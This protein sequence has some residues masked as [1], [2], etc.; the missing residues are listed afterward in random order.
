MRL[1][2][3]RI[4][5]NQT[6]RNFFHKNGLGQDSV[7]QALAAFGRRA[8]IFFFDE[9][10]ST[11]LRALEL[12]KNILNPFI[13]IAGKQ[14]AGRGRFDR[15]W[16][17]ESGKSICLSA[18][19]HL[20]ALNT[21]NLGLFNII[22]GICICK[23]LRLY[24]GADLL[25]KWPN[26]IYFRGKKLGGMIASVQSIGSKP[27]SLLFGIGVNFAPLSDNAGLNSVSLTEASPVPVDLVQTAAV[28]SDA[29]FEAFDILIQNRDFDIAD[30]FYAL[31][32]LRGK[33]IAVDL[34]G[35]RHEGVA[36][37][38]DSAGSLILRMPCGEIFLAGAGE[39]SI[40]KE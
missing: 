26:D 23:S 3:M 19:F 15:L 7:A 6:D 10:D 22:A 21:P 25:L 33:T 20:N 16:R 9:V 14:T 27:A 8:D 11:N 18:L 35:S 30:E 4:M 39:S 36:D 13:V 31:D 1:D 34:C 24:S 40:V 32:F 28:V 37:G 12:A 17:D 38:V 2:D 5:S 29:V